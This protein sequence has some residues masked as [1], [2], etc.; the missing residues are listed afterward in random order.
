MSELAC[1]ASAAEASWV[2]EVLHYWFHGLGEVEWWGKHPVV[3]SEIQRR[4][5]VLHER[6]LADDGAG[7]AGPRPRLAAVLALDQFARHL[8][9][10]SPRAFAAD[11]L[12]RR[13]ARAAIAA[14]DDQALTHAQRLFLYLPFE[15]SEDRADQALAVALI[16][17]LGNA[18]WGD[19]ARAHQAIIVRFGRFP[20]RNAVLGRTSTAEETA[21]LAQ[22]NSA[23]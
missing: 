23:F 6:L 7:L 2:E 12:A 3:D 17:R 9:R 18:S 13:L 19:F 16:D 10:D 5:G 21:F 11:P 22:P 20:H 15:H 14:G 1:T 8:F 4:F